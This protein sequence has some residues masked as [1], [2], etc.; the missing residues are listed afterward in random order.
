MATKAIINEMIMFDFKLLKISFVILKSQEFK[1]KIYNIGTMKINNETPNSIHD[2][3][4]HLKSS[5][6]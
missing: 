6:E 2:F 3:L 4:R 5:L 1:N